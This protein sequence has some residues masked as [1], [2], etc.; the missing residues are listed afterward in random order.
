MLGHAASSGDDVY[1]KMKKPIPMSGLG[2][3]RFTADKFKFSLSQYGVY[4]C[5]SS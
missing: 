2:P 4:G 1:S 3:R 5:I